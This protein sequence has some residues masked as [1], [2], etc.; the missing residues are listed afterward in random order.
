MELTQTTNKQ[1][2]VGAYERLSREDSKLEESSSIKSQRMI[3]ES[4]AKFN[5]LPIIKHYSDDGFTGSNFERP[6]FEELK[7]DIEEGSINCVIVKD[8]SRLGR[9][10]YLT[11]DYI[12]S[13]FLEHQV[14]FIAINDGYDSMMEDS[15]LGMRLSLNDMY[16]R[17]FSKKIRSSLDMKR[18]NGEYIATY[19]KYGYLK[20]SK[21]P[22]HL[23]IDR[24]TSPIIKQMYEWALNGD[25]SVIIAHRLTEMKIPIPSV[26]K[27]QK[28]EHFNELLNTDTGIW[29]SQTVRDI[30]SSEIYLGHMVQGK[31]KKL[32]Y[33]SK[34]LKKTD[35][36]DWFIVEN[37]HEAIIDQET[38]DKVQE[39]L[40]SKS[41]K[42]S[43]G[44]KRKYLFQGLIH[45][46]ECGSRL[47]I[48]SDKENR[49]HIQCN[50]FSRYGKF[51]ICYSHYLSYDK[52]ERNLLAF[53]CE[54]GKGFLETYD[55]NSLKDK[56]QN[57]NPS[58]ISK[59]TLKKNTISKKIEHQ[60]ELIEILYE[61]RLLDE[62]TVKEYQKKS[63]ICNE[64]I[65]DLENE[66]ETIEMELQI[67][68][69]NQ[70]Q[71]PKNNLTH[72]IVEFLSFEK[73][74]H[75]L[76]SQLIDKI[77]IDKDKNVEVFFKVNITEYI[78]LEKKNG[79]ELY[80]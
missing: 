43:A 25:G 42:Y 51:N 55:I 76:I 74:T 45:C 40:K 60:H 75:E 71:L 49:N 18:K 67:I 13:Y 72:L 69:S 50:N 63:K 54:I 77:V 36:S 57:V 33:N 70:L 5:H 64:T 48:Y 16:L 58:N 52:L 46:K 62:I 44:N 65:K 23:I 27:K 1:Y 39:I 31:Y 53:L 35:K 4:F 8:L 17:D 47:N 15:L 3:I 7:K 37:T 6:G 10:L 41:K 56:T 30:L 28:S 14:R 38:F 2:L 24:V 73:P 12:E 66:L 20:D 21:N 11:G 80:V 26:Y 29:R 9:D 61:Q 79:D 78:T 68:Q 32:S 59:L 34:S 22:K 19:P